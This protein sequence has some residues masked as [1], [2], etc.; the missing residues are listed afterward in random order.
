MIFHSEEGQI[1]LALCFG[2]QY[3]GYA[4]ESENWGPQKSRLIITPGLQLL[5]GGCRDNDKGDQIL[6]TF[7]IY[8][9]RSLMQNINSNLYILDIV[10]PKGK[11]L[12]EEFA[13]VLTSLLVGKG[14]TSKTLPED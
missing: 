3:H 1:R 5:G 2:Y 7:F 4:D 9:S 13:S 6:N 10:I 11:Q 12:H 14:L 8:L